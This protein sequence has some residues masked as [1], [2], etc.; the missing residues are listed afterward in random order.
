LK[1]PPTLRILLC[2]VPLLAGCKSTDLARSGHFSHFTGLTDFSSFAPTRDDQ[3][4]QVLLSPTVPSPRP[5]NQLIVSWNAAAASGSLLTVEAAGIFPNGRTKF[6][7]LAKWS[8]DAQASPR[9]SMWGQGDADGTVN[10]DTL[11][12]NRLASGAQIRLT[13][14]GA[15]GTPPAL[16]FLGLSFC[17]TMAATARRPS[18]RLARGTTIATPERSQRGYAGNQGWCSPASLSMILAR[19]AVV[20]NRPELDLPPVVSRP[21]ATRW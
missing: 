17:D 15:T 11:V 9:T 18:N 20:L 4:N 10:T 16:K 1:V 12:L 21:E 13:L 2:T 5:W 7:T 14:V 8:P 3:G 19:W 6:Y